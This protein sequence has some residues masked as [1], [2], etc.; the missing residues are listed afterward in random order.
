MNE[1]L[2]NILFYA[3]FPVLAVILGGIVAAFRSPG[4]RMRSAVQHFAAGIVFAAIAFELLPEIK[5]E[6]APLAAMLGFAAGIGLMLVIKIV[7]G[8]FGEG[9]AENEAA[10]DR[11]NA[12]DAATAKFERSAAAQP[13]PQNKQ[14]TS[15]L[16]TLGVD[17]LVDGLLIG[18]GFAAG[19]KQGLMLLVALSIEALF[20]GLSAAVALAQV[21][22]SWARIIGTNVG[23]SLLLA[24]G[25]V[26]G[27]FVFGNL[28][29]AAK[30]IVLSFGA[31]ALLY[32][33][34]EELLVEAHE[35]P[36]TP[37]LTAMFFVGF[38]V[39]LVVEMI[40]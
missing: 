18:I 12:P 2:L 28:T 32:L 25:V 37:L 5:D 26:A 9:A 31:A 10:G 19:V 6:R 30:E 17:I 21:G 1:S 13:T 38:V 20:L 7:V 23:L 16:I 15:L 11:E 35:E 3:L 24:A 4:A 14:P 34:T 40:A 22:A 29:G 39:L 36:E 33:V 27:V 8:K